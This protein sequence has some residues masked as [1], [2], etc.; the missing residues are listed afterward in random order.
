MARGT[1][2]ALVA[3]GDVVRLERIHPATGQRRGLTNFSRLAFGQPIAWDL[4]VEPD[5]QVL[6]LLADTPGPAVPDDGFSHTW[7]AFARIDPVTGARTAV[8]VAPR[9]EGRAVAAREPAGTIVVAVKDNLLGRFGG[10]VVRIDPSTG[11]A[12]VLTLS[13]FD[14]ASPTFVLPVAVAVAPDGRLFVTASAPTQ[15]RVVGIDAH[16]GTPGPAFPGPDVTPAG[17][18]AVDQH[19]RVLVMSGPALLR[20]DL[21]TGSREVLA[22]AVPGVHD[23]VEEPGGTLV[24]ADDSGLRRLDPPTGALTTLVVTPVDPDGASPPSVVA[25]DVVW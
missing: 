7:V 12:T 2:V 25:V 22:P 13:D 9:I 3:D 11:T 18:L 20:V 19:G 1:I 17:P 21:A 15:R 8:P 23:L 24:L 10:G 4:L 16:T 6:V 5:G 14:A